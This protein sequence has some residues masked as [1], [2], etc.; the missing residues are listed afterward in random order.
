MKNSE[1][2]PFPKKRGGTPVADGLSISPPQHSTQFNMMSTSA[3][4]LTMLAGKKS[5]SPKTVMQPGQ[6]KEVKQRRSF[7]VDSFLDPG[8]ASSP[9]PGKQKAKS[10]NVAQPMP[11]KPSYHSEV[12]EFRDEFVSAYPS[13]HDSYLFFDH[14]NV[15][16][17]SWD[18]ST[19][20]AKW[21][22]IRSTRTAQRYVWFGAQ[23]SSVF[24]WL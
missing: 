4:Q 23:R 2:D 19:T 9:T 3:S 10:I 7:I 24:R 12:G 15:S 6:S 14:S 1:K 13:Q 22:M 5:P 16:L 17:R 18:D 21:A 20:P 8:L 11:V